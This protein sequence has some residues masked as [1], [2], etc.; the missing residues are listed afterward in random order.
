M[1]TRFY[2]PEN[3]YLRGYTI[4]SKTPNNEQYVFIY[5]DTLLIETLPSDLTNLPGFSKFQS[6]GIQI[7][8]KEIGSYLFQQGTY[9]QVA[10]RNR[11]N[12]I[13]A[14]QTEIVLYFTKT[15]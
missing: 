15:S 1:L 2:I 4:K 8:F 6:G 9:L 13:S 7:E 14:Q 12:T 5:K 11:T 10:I 3:C